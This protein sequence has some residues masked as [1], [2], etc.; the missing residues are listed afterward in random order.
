MNRQQHTVQYANQVWYV[1]DNDE[2]DV[3]KT[4]SGDYANKKVKREAETLCKQ[5]NKGGAQ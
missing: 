3:V 4:F 1:Y 2:G 5:L